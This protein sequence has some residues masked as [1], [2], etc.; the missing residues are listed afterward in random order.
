MKH[1][2][3]SCPSKFKCKIEGCGALHHTLLHK[4]ESLKETAEEKDKNIELPTVTSSTATSKAPHAVLLRVIPVRVIGERQVA[5]TYA[6]LDSGSEITL[7]DPSLVKQVGAQGHLDKLVV[8]TVS[9]E[10]DVQHGYRINLSVESLINENPKRLKLTNAWSSKELKIPLRHQ[11]VFQDKS[12]WPHL[13]NVPFPNVEREKISIIIGTD[14]P[15]VFIPIDVCYD[16]P[17]SPVAIPSCLGYSVFG[18]MG[19]EIEA[20]CSTAYTSAVHNVCVS[21]DIALNQQLESFW[22]LESLGTSRDN[23]KTMSVQDKQALKVIEKTLTKVDSHYQMGLL[24]KNEDTH[25]PNNRTVAEIRLKHLKRRLER[26]PKL[27]MKYLAIID[28]YVV[29]GYARKL[30]KNEATTK[31]DKTWY[32]PHHPVIN[33]RK[34]EKVRVVFDAASTF[35]DTSLNDQLLQGPDLMN[36]LVGVLIRFRQFAVALIADIE[37]MFHQVKVQPEDCDVLRFLLWNDDCQKP[38][39]EYKML[40]HIF[41][42]KSSPCCANKALLQTA[43][44]NELKY[45]KDV[46]EVVRRNFYVDDLLKSTATDEEAIDLAL[47]LIDM[48]AEGGFRLTKF[49]S[50]RKDVLKAIPAKERATPTLDLVLDQLPINRTLGLSWDAQ[51]DEFYFSSIRTDK[52]ATKRGILSVIS[53]L[54]DPLGFLGPFILPVK[55]LLQELWRQGIGWDE[56]I[57]EKE[58]EIWQYWLQSLLQLSDIRIP[59]C[60]IVTK[61]PRESTELHMFSDASEVAYSA[62]AYVRITDDQGGIHCSFVM[63][64]CRNSPIRRPTILRLELLASVMAAVRLSNLIR[65][66][67]DWKFDS[68]VSFLESSIQQM[69]DRGAYQYKC[70][71][72][73][74]V[75]C[76]AQ[77]FCTKALINGHA[78]RLPK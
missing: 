41:G 3:R 61:I 15:E 73:S 42:A 40:V 75:G 4:P 9:N 59:R 2:A 68:G 58:L 44:D 22:K 48:L 63:G 30:T 1:T 77:I 45:G 47:K 21:S 66:E 71:K 29:K 55:I 26:D 38:L 57:S 52:P 20:Q 16:G 14:M 50:N 67:F 18:R 56:E 11:R 43:D 36:N 78:Q 7:V 37:A 31:S 39:E 46:A 65:S 70:S 69:T 60:Y 17:D 24:W 28:D 74:V 62:S 25:L 35:N 76:Q 72:R 27:K 12:R 34:P 8:S 54:F 5:T 6:M 32:L 49:L 10:N 23:S 64:K 53:S 51:T 13:Q 33:P 19:K